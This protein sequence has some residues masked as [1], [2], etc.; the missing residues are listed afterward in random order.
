MSHLNSIRVG[1]ESF[2]IKTVKVR[3]Y[4]NYCYLFLLFFLGTY[5][6]FAPELCFD[7][8]ERSSFPSDVWA[9]GCVLLEIMTKKTPWAD[10]YEQGSILLNAL[11]KPENASIFQNICLSQKAPEKLRAILCHCCT[12]SK[13]DR[14]SFPTIIRDLISIAENELQKTNQRQEKS[15]QPTSSYARPSSGAPKPSNK[16]ASS[17]SRA[18]AISDDVEDV[19]NMFID[20]SSDSENDDLEIGFTSDVKPTQY[21]KGQHT[22]EKTSACA[23]PSSGAR[24]CSAKTPS[25]CGTSKNKS[26]AAERMRLLFGTIMI[27]AF[28]ELKCDSLEH[29]FGLCSNPAC[30]QKKPSTSAQSTNHDSSKDRPLFKGP[31]GG[32]YYLTESGK[33]QYIK[34]EDQ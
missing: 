1:T 8:P 16:A 30:P 17:S 6:W 14:P 12:W 19:P 22:T 23:R 3:N 28:P 21:R 26:A 31:R 13:T 27:D 10:Q 7:R 18:K 33:K 20:N 2:S 34:D 15:Q 9:F 4:F 11:S 24:R 25:S 32:Y 5:R 29:S